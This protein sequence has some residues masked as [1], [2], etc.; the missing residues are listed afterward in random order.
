MAPFDWKDSHCGH[1]EEGRLL[2]LVLD[3]TPSSDGA[4]GVYGDRLVLPQHGNRSEVGV[5]LGNSS[6]DLQWKWHEEIQCDLSVFLP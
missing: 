5:F 6:Y 1:L 4:G 2:P 3:A